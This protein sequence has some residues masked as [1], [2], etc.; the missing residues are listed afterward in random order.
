MLTFDNLE[1]NRFTNVFDWPTFE[2]E[3][4]TFAQEAIVAASL[5]HGVD[6]IVEEAKANIVRSTQNVW[7]AILIEHRPHNNYDLMKIVFYERVVRAAE[8]KCQGK[9]SSL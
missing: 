4:R 8:G 7:W 5:A 1:V 6:E 9:S 3:C 2:G